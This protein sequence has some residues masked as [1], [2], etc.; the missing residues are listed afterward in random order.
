MTHGKI[1]GIPCSLRTAI[2]RDTLSEVLDR[3]RLAQPDDYERLRRVVRDVIPLSP[4]ETQDG[5]DLG[6]WKMDKAQDDDPKT[7]GYGCGDETPGIMYVNEGL[8]RRKLV[9]TMAHELGHACTVKDDL[10]ARGDL[11]YEEWASELT[12]DWY[13]DK[14]WGFGAEIDS[15]RGESRLMHHG[16]APGQ[17]FSLEQIEF[18]LGKDYVCRRISE[19]TDPTV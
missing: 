6:E 7:W 10:E 11:P 8:P 18:E 12:A 1:H 16:P 15:V 9:P 19:R 14:R 3:I 17:R 5:S 13:A 2:A 4:E